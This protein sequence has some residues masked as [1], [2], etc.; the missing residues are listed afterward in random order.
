M[1]NESLLRAIR[2]FMACVNSGASQDELDRI[3]ISLLKEL[4]IARLIAPIT[5]K[6]LNN[7]DLD[8]MNLEDGKE[9]NF[10]FLEDEN[11]DKFYPIFSDL[12]KFEEFEFENVEPL[13]I[14]I[15]DYANIFS[16]EKVALGVVI[17]PYDE[18]FIMDKNMVLSIGK[19]SIFE[20]IGQNE[21]LVFITPKSEPTNLL[22][23]LSTFFVQID[24]VKQANFMLVKKGG[25]NGFLFIIDHNYN[26]EIELFNDIYEIAYSTFKDELVYIVSAKEEIFR[27]A[28]KLTKP[29]YEKEN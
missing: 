14:T 23:R 21:E 4:E 28:S 2:D 3:D 16:K 11:S 15:K 26:D 29:F 27:N 24:E 19:K 20:D 9:I 18:S 7:T 12:K 5:T 22:D 17:N 10:I 6:A 1:K 13:E 25:K 8:P